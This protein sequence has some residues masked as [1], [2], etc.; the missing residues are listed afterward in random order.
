M[1]W[2]EFFIIEPVEENNIIFDTETNLM[3]TKMPIL[4]LHARDDI[5]IPYELGEKVI[6]LFTFL[7]ILNIHNL[8]QTK[9]LSFASH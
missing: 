5:V 3:N 2:F 8:V 7:S 4:I 1:P 6:L 9:S